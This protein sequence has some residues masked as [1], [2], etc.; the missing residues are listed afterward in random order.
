MELYSVEKNSGISIE[1]G[2]NRIY[3]QDCDYLGI[4]LGEGKNV[5]VICKTHEHDV[6]DNTYD[7]IISTEMFEHDPWWKKSIVNMIRMLKTGGFL[8][9]TCATTG[10]GVHGTKETSPSNCP[11]QQDHYK[12]LTVADFKSVLNFNKI[13]EWYIFT[14]F[15]INTANLYF[16]GVKK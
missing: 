16:I 13:F 3:F 8:L 1:Y 11:F 15:H 4:D 14:D 9:I 7:T 2:N 6:P 12:N 5:D 10:R